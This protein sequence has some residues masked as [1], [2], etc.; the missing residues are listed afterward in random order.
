MVIRKGRLDSNIGIDIW[1]NREMIKIVDADRNLGFTFNDNL[2]WTNHVNT[3]VDEV[4]M[5]DPI[6]YAF[7]Y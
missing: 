1:M 7:E 2:A 3:F 4:S 5:V 6:F